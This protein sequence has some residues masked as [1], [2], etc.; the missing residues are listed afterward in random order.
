MSDNPSLQA[1]Y[2]PYNTCF[3]CGQANEHGLRLQSFPDGDLVVARWR[4]Q[5]HHEAFTGVLN[6]GIIGSLL[7]CHGDWTAIWSMMQRDVLAEAPCMVTAEFNVKL[8]KPTPTDSE[9]LIH[10]RT[11][12]LGRRHAIVETT[13]LADGE[14]CARCRGAFVTVRPGHPAWHAW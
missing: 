6:G 3:G 9:L 1:R 8:L 13:L 7:D 10:G 5:P 14:A 2:A 12:E 4:P 11:I